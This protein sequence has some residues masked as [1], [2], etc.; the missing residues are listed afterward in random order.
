MGR[1]EAIIF[2]EQYRS[3]VV[4]CQERRISNR[5]MRIGLDGPH[6]RDTRRERQQTN[7]SATSDRRRLYLYLSEPGES[8]ATRLFLSPCRIP[9]SSSSSSLSSLA[10]RM[11]CLQIELERLTCQFGLS[12]SLSAVLASASTTRRA[13][14][15]ERRVGL[16]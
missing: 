1:G 8:N 10:S 12:L 9:S 11:F 5:T 16:G 7:N 4:R 15:R 2:L 3:R 6:K 13:R 14:A